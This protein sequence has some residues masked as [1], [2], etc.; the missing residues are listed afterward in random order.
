MCHLAS[1]RLATDEA[2]NDFLTAKSQGLEAMEKFV[3]NCL[4]PNGSCSFY[5]R[6]PRLSHKTF[7]TKSTNKKKLTSEKLM[8]G[9]RD[10]F[11][12]LFILGH[13][14]IDPEE[15]LSYSLCSLPLAIATPVGRVT[16]TVKAS[17]LKKLEH[18]SQSIIE[19]P[20]NSICLV[21]DAMDIL[22]KVK[23]IDGVDYKHF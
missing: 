8:K 17:L 9:T 2:V 19:P 6:I 5:S 11:A 13:R 7:E 23:V 21:V 22:Q 18:Y 15:L 1:G 16:K 12:R 4:D 14:K 10:L 20:V 3:N